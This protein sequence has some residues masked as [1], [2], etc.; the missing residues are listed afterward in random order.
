ME[1]PHV[2]F[3]CSVFFQSLGHNEHQIL[4]LFISF[5][6]LFPKMYSYNKRWF[7]V[8]LLSVYHTYCFTLLKLHF[9]SCVL[10][11][12]SKVYSWDEYGGG[13]TKT[14]LQCVSF[15]LCLLLHHYVIIFQEMKVMKC[16]SKYYKKMVYDEILCQFVLFSQCTDLL[17]WLNLMHITA[18]IK[19]T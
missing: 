9:T 4:Q 17:P 13:I 1:A 3:F 2:P 15:Y 10:D 14:M 19:S 11:I 18:K 8:C 7:Y 5:Q 12:R 6:R 16:I